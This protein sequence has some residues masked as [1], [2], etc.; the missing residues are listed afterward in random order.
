MDVS[1]EVVYKKSSDSPP[2]REDTV[3]AIP[4]I[5]LGFHLRT[6]EQGRRG[7]S[8]HRQHGGVEFSGNRYILFAFALLMSHC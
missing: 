4:L 6:S 7:F 3:A 8:T 2:P 1:F 5:F